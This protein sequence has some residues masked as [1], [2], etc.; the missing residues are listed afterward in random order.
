MLRNLAQAVQ[1]Q[2]RERVKD[3]A[4]KA[5]PG[6]AYAAKVRELASAGG[7]LTRVAVCPHP[8]AVARIAPHA[9]GLH[10]VGD[11]GAIVELI[12]HGVAKDGGR[13]LNLFRRAC[14]ADEPTACVDAAALMRR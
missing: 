5:D 4:R 11:H 3:A 9:A 1:R 7:E 6:R 2:E 8:G 12:K 10:Q 14:D 13:A